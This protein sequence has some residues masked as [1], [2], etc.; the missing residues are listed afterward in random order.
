MQKF[1]HVSR[2]AVSAAELN[3]KLMRWRTL[4]SLDLDMLSGV[5]CLLLGVGTLGCE[6]ARILMVS[7]LNNCTF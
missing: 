6:V 2:L 3:L 1:G 4:P 5:R 7:I